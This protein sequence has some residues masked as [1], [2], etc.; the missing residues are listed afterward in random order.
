MDLENAG[1]SYAVA[2][3]LIHRG[4]RNMFSWDENKDDLSVRQKGIP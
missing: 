4:V 2:G 1:S 3:R